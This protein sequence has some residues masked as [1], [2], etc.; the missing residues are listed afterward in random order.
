MKFHW[1]KFFCNKYICSRSR[2][3]RD[4]RFASAAFV[5]MEYLSET[6]ETYEKYV[7][8]NIEHVGSVEKFLTAFQY[9]IPNRYAENELQT[10]V[11]MQIFL[12]FQISKINI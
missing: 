1:L 9:V 11:C 10:E 6:V 3:T 4:A 12:L 7:V 8:E 5:A 2:K